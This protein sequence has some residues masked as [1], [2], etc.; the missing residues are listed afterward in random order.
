MLTRVQITNFKSIG[1]GPDGGPGVDMELK[2]LTF[3]V[4]P[5]GGGKSSILE[6]IALA[7]SGDQ[8]YTLL[9]SSSPLRLLRGRRADSRAAIELAIDGATYRVLVRGADSPAP[10]KGFIRVVS[11]FDGEI[12]AESPSMSQLV[13]SDRLLG[14]ARG[15]LS[16]TSFL[17]STRGAIP[18]AESTG[19]E[20]PTWV[21][22]NG[23]HLQVFYGHVP[24]E[25]V[26]EVAR[27]AEEFDLLRARTKLRSQ[28]HVA[29]EYI[30]DPGSKTRLDSGLKTHLD[31]ALASSGQ[32]QAFA[33]LVQVAGAPQGGRILI[34]EPEIS[35]HPKAQ[36][37]MTRFLA[38]HAA[39]AAK[40]KQIIA[41]THS[42]FMLLALQYPVEE[43][44]IKP[45]QIAV[46]EVERDK[47]TGA[48]KAQ[49]LP[50]TKDGYL[51]NWVPSFSR[52]EKKLLRDWLKT[53]PEA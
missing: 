24:E 14:F 39:H 10:P 6:A 5:N 33:V 47:K 46:Y 16:T 26:E 51:K 41:T 7:C 25:V 36:V 42:P 4:G 34:E 28:G 37:E 35:L 50:M 18:E 22:R 44:L 17:A 49:P 52:V 30:D 3:L 27:A 20:L 8:L 40:G 15:L 19:G 48:T 21:G 29:V 31:L 1:E 53:L 23:E 43:G 11:T 12:L 9:G 2:P 45:D 38:E 32:R 13:D